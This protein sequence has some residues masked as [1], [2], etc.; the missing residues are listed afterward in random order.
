MTTKNNQPDTQNEI[1][2]TQTFHLFGILLICALFFFVGLVDSPFTHHNFY[3]T[4]FV[5]L[6]TFGF[7]SS[8]ILLLAK[9]NL[10]PPNLKKLSAFACLFSS[11]MQW[12]VLAIDATRYEI[13]WSYGLLHPFWSIVSS[14]SYSTITFFFSLSVIPAL[15]IIITYLSLLFCIRTLCP[16]F[17]N[18]VPA[19][20][21]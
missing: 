5:A 1:D 2:S 8:A 6:I 18:A 7:F 4:F 20:S 14:K 15:I 19:Q 13:T 16:T 9:L 10:F 21:N 11:I 17:T 12:T 3:G